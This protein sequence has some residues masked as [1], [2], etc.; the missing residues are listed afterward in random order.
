MNQQAAT[1]IR[2][3]AVIDSTV[4]KDFHYKFRDYKKGEVFERN[5]NNSSHNSF[6]RSG[7]IENFPEDQ[8]EYVCVKFNTTFNTKQYKL[9]DIIPTEEVE[10]GLSELLVRRRVIAK[11]LKGFSESQKNKKTE[12]TVK[13]TVEEKQE[14]ISTDIQEDIPEE[15]KTDIPTVEF[16]TELRNAQVA[17]DILN[18]HFDEYRG[19][20][21]SYGFTDFTTSLGFTYKAFTKK[22][23]AEAVVDYLTKRNTPKS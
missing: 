15:E 10:Y 12:E 2:P 16:L 8:Y 3:N 20:I 6:K 1:D 14:Q 5:P 7:R 9:F 17:K 13:E 18:C 11:K 21:K 4:L 23:H 22:E 19:I